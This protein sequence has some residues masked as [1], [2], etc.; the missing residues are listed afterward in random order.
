MWVSFFCQSK[1]PRGFVNLSVITT[2]SLCSPNSQR[3][4]PHTNPSSMDRKISL[5]WKQFETGRASWAYD[6]LIDNLRRERERSLNSWPPNPA[7][8]Q[9]SSAAVQHAANSSTV[10]FLFSWSGEYSN[11]VNE[12]GGNMGNFC[13]NDTVSVC[14]EPSCYY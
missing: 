12:E 10:Y 4:L 8:F 9:L 6:F 3:P 11:P 7:C 1:H 13:G 14:C 5:S 2:K